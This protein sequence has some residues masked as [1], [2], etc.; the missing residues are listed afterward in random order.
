[1]LQPRSTWTYNTMNPEEIRPGSCDCVDLHSNMVS[2]LT[3]KP[4]K[5]LSTPVEK[6]H[7]MEE[8]WQGFPLLVSEKSAQSTICEST[9]RWSPGDHHLPTHLCLGEQIPDKDTV[10]GCI[11]WRSPPHP[12]ILRKVYYLKLSLNQATQASGLRKKARGRL[13]PLEMQRELSTFTYYLGS[14]HTLIDH[15]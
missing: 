12:P 14:L 15:K 7:Q 3:P 8:T 2:C 10:P 4:W 5:A 11:S 13:S 6:H 9:I 1:M